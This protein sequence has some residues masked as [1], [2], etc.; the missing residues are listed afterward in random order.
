VS[1][2]NRLATSRSKGSPPY[3]FKP[4]NEV[5]IRHELSKPLADQRRSE[6]RSYRFGHG[7]T[8]NYALTSGH[9]VRPDCYYMIHGNMRIKV[10]DVA[11]VAVYRLQEEPVGM[12]R[13][14]PPKQRVRKPRSAVSSAIKC[15]LD[16]EPQK[17]NS[18]GQM[19]ASIPPARTSFR[20]QGWS[21][22]RFG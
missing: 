5:S 1:S 12:H 11:R 8:I 14:I 6:V 2:S 22:E 13:L 7:V 4:A 10:R 20:Y 16:C 18:R 15:N 9:A 21:P 3:I 17:T 19:K